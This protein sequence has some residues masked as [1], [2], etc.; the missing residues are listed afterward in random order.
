MNTE[1]R[2]NVNPYSTIK[3]APNAAWT[4]VRI[5]DVVLNI[6]GTT[7]PN[8]EEYHE[9]IAVIDRIAAALKTCREQVVAELGPVIPLSESELRVLD[10]NR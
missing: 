7:W 1:I 9:R 2:V 4:Q 5:D 3:V 10:G 6:C 8:I